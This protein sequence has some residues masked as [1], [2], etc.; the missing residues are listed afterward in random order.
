M[1]EQGNSNMEHVHMA[2]QGLWFGARHHKTLRPRQHSNGCYG[3]EE[4]G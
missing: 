2:M 1:M 4:P 3:D